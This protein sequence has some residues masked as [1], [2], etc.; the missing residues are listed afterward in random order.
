[1]F[2]GTL[3][4]ITD[5]FDVLYNAIAGTANLQLLIPAA[6]LID[7]SAFAISKLWGMQET[8]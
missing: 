3:L 6:A 8:A 4:K 2:S 1:M 5:V 7:G